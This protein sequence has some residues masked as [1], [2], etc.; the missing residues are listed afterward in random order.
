MLNFNEAYDSL[1]LTEKY[2][3]FETNAQYYQK[4]LLNFQ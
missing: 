1:F 4:N 3:N 2:K